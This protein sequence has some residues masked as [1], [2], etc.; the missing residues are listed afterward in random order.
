MDERRKMADKWHFI[1][2]NHTIDELELVSAPSLVLA[3]TPATKK[4]ISPG[5]RLG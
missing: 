2:L 4:A 1:L 3:G 5:Y